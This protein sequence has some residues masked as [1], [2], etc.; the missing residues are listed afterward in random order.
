L[1]PQELR[2]CL[3]VSID[4]TALDWLE[5]L[6]SDQAFQSTVVVPD[7][8]TDEQYPLELVLRFLAFHALPTVNQQELRSLHQYLDDVAI[9][10]AE[11]TNAAQ[12]DRL[13]Q[14]FRES[15]RLMASSG[16][17]ELLKRWN[18]GKQQFQGPFLSTAYEVLAMGIGYCVANG[19][20][21]R[22]DLRSAAQELWTQHFATGQSSGKSAERRIAENLPLG[23]D[24][25]QL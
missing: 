9:N 10:L 20:P 22:T 16:G 13:S 23:R 7:R 21:V 25:V 11:S 2:S 6:V 12:R 17:D 18:P 5:E 19:I 24:L 3:I 1:T 8:L 15:F 14:V 4:A